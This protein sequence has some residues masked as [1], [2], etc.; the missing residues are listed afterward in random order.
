MFLKLNKILHPF[1]LTS[2]TIRPS[3]LGCFGATWMFG[4][5][6][7]CDGSTHVLANIGSEVTRAGLCCLAYRLRTGCITFVDVHVS[8]YIRDGNLGVWRFP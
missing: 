2:L 5:L 7:G 1:W 4:C 8:R 3:Q 6:S